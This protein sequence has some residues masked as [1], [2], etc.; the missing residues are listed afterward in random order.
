M[1]YN[2]KQAKK[3]LPVKSYQSMNCV[4]SGAVEDVYHAMER[5]FSDALLVGVTNTHL[6]LRLKAVDVL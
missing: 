3:I 2:P 5:K 6:L 4:I 1:I